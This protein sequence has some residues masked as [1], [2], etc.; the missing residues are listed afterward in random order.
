LGLYLVGEKEPSSI[1]VEVKEGK[2]ITLPIED[3]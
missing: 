3:E 2:Q 1:E